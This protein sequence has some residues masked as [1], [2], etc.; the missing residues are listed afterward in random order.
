LTQ[1]SYLLG[2]ARVSTND[3]N[4]ALQTDALEAAGCARLFVDRGVSGKLARRPELDK[5]LDIARP[6][7]TLVVWKLDRLG[8]DTRNLL[9]LMA[10]LN[11][12][13]VK[14]RSLTEGV[15]TEGPMGTAF[16]TIISAFAQLERD[17]I[18]ERTRAGLETARA[19]GRVG[20][21][22][23]ILTPDQK[24][25]VNLLYQAKSQT[26]NKI[27]ATFKVSRSTVTRIVKEA[28]PDVP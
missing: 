26:L 2:Y 10:D 8:R 13:G 21:R 16:I 14:F 9:T 22:P 27:A 28:K 18:V 15:T 5:L 24:Q 7:D 19:H 23:G 25:A 3:Q 6:G 11:D 1:S 4:P 12:R 20:G 17:V